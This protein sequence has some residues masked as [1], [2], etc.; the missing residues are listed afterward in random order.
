ME[1]G[2]LIGIYIS[3][4]K[5]VPMQYK[6]IIQANAGLG[7]EGDR[8]VSDKGAFSKHREE[9]AIRHVTLI[10]AEA[11]YEANEILGQDKGRPFL[12]EDTRRNL[13][14][15]GI[16]LNDLIDREFTVGDVRMRGTEICDPCERPSK[17]SGK[18]GFKEAFEGRGGIRAE[19]ISGGEIKRDDI[20]EVYTIE[21][22]PQ[23]K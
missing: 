1:Q 4:D 10:E 21:T 13:I 5:G 18:K 20:I 16:N 9:E 17:L 8:Y 15:R 19:I 3:T 11:V 14:T 23:I 2:K 7:L 12:Y 22:Q 6:N